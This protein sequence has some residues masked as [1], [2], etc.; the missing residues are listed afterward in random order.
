MLFYRKFRVGDWKLNG[1][2]RLVGQEVPHDAYTDLL[3]IQ[4]QSIFPSAATDLT[5]VNGLSAP[6]GAV[7]ASVNTREVVK[8]VSGPQTPKAQQPEL[9][10]WIPLTTESGGKV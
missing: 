8:I 1:W 10:L 3:T 4:G 9:D 5:D 6:G 2:K 7:S